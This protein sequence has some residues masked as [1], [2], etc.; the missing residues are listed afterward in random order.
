MAQKIVVY[1]T[2]T[3][4]MV[5]T[6]TTIDAIG[7]GFTDV[8][9]DVSAGGQTVFSV[10]GTADITASN[11]VDVFVNGRLSREGASYDFTRNASNDTITTSYTVP[12]DTWVRVRVYP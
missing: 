11:K 4:E 12:Q 9:F 5:A 8:D 10:A 1:D 2:S 6:T 3:R 7:G